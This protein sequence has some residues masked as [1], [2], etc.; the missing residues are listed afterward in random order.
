MSLALFVRLAYGPNVRDDAYITL[1]YAQHLATGLG[2]TFNTGERVMGTTTPLFTIL[3][4]AIARLGVDPVAGAVALGV[5]AD[6]LTVIALWWLG[7]RLVGEAVGL[8]ASMVYALSTPIVAHAVSGMETPLYLLLIVGAFALAE[9]G[10][11]LLAAAVC[12]LLVLTRPDGALVPIAL[13]GWPI[14]GTIARRPRLSLRHDLGRVL[15]RG[16]LPGLVFTA[17][18]AL[19][20]ALA[21]RYF[22]SPLPQSVVAKWDL[23][24]EER[25]RSL[26]NLV[27]YFTDLGPRWFLPLSALALLGLF[28]VVRRPRAGPLLIW[29]ALYT[30]AFL[31]TDKFLYP[32]WP[33]EWYFLPLLPTLSIS[34]AAGAVRLAARLALPQWARRAAVGAATAGA[35]VLLWTQRA[36][37]EKIVQGREALYTHLAAELGGRYGAGADRVAAW[38]IG[39]LGY[40]H[41]GPILDLHGL[42]TPSAVGRGPE[43]V[44][45]EDGPP[46]FVSF[47]TSVPSAMAAAEWFEES[48][49]PV[50]QLENWE[51]RRLILFRRYPEPRPSRAKGAVLGDDLELVGRRVAWD[52]QPPGSLLRVELVWRA[53]HV[54]ADRTSLSLQLFDDGTRLAQ[55]DNEPQEGT[56][57]T[58]GL[59]PGQLIA[60]RYDL[61]VPERPAEGAGSLALAGYPTERPQA[62]LTWR[63]PAGAV[64]G[65]HLALPLP[66]GARPVSEIACRT[67]FAGGVGLAAVGLEREGDGVWLTLVWEA[68]AP[69]SDDYTAFVH[70]LDGERLVGQADGP[71]LDGNPPTSTWEVGDRLVERRRL[72]ASALGATRVL[73]GLYLPRTG[74]RMV[75]A[76]GRGDAATFRPGPEPSCS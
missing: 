3:L 22:G 45:A 18:V 4:A 58:T 19:W 70:A 30:L 67:V 46:W 39:A 6:L 24:T 44:L 10:R 35:L 36:D 31:V 54:P 76:D 2:F 56:R 23:A 43:Q 57:P 52:D 42:V 74:Q 14:L 73:V 72:P 32:D 17:P 20:S 61:V 8:L 50:R 12:A 53:R 59:R 47:H 62:A 5:A 41:P 25:F 26:T 51:S 9:A 1:R 29:T 48:Y 13:A 7:R 75:R 49:R 40:T 71:P 34:A 27:A 65:S 64:L 69:P 16:W 60:D 28:D 38:E 33:F 37:L 55:Q 68:L 11:V 66:L 15:R 21:W 63:S